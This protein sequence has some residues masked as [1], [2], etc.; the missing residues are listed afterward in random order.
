MHNNIAIDHKVRASVRTSPTIE[1]HCSFYYE[2]LRVA[3]YKLCLNTTVKFT[4]K[5]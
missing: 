4:L 1:W 2:I 5:F 3:D